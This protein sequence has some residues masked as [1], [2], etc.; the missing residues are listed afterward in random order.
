MGEPLEYSLR[1]RYGECDMQGVLFNSHYLAW[2]DI[3][4]RSCF[5]RHSAAIS[6]FSIA[7]GT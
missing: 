7:A 3:S 4:I 5:A 1:V 2:F 6:P